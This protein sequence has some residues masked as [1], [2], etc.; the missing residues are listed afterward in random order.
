MRPFR[1]FILAGVALALALAGG[2]ASAWWAL[3]NEVGFGEITVGPWVAAPQLGQPD[4]DPYSRAQLAR[5]GVIPLGPAEGVR[6]SASTDDRGRTLDAA[7]EYR[8]HGTLPPSRVWTLRTLEGRG[9]AD[10]NRLPDALNSRTVL[11]GDNGR[12][13]VAVAARAQPGNWLHVGAAGSFTLALTLYDTP[14]SGSATLS[15]IRLPAITRTDC[16]VR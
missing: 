12:I 13:D 5:G 6:F 15:D 11:H 8:L 4:A 2:V 1:S 16:N 7:C 9:P 14:V 10:E 3:D